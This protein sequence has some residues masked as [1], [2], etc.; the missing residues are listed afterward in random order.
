MK[1]P[2]VAVLAAVIM[3]GGCSSHYHSVRDGHVD[4]YLKAPEVQSVSLVISG[5]TFEQ[6]PAART[7]LGDWKATINKTVEFRYF[8]LV[9]GKV[10]LPD[11]RLKERDDFGADNCIY[12]P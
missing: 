8:Y 7:L 2:I 12:S 11:C 4:V 5:D 3:A 10:Y 9:D 1:H 6:V